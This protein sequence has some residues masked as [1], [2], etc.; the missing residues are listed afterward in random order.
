MTDTATTAPTPPGSLDFAKARATLQ[1]IYG[2]P[3]R[4]A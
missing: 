4:R 3:C 2:T 1:D